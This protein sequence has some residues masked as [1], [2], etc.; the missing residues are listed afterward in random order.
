MKSVI[1]QQ[2]REK[3]RTV[4]NRH[5]KIKETLLIQELKPTLNDT[6]SSEKLY[7]FQFAFFNASFSQ[8]LSLLLLIISPARFSWTSDINQNMEKHQVLT[9]NKKFY[10][11][12]DTRHIYLLQNVVF[13]DEGFG[14]NHAF[15]ANRIYNVSILG[16]SRVK[17]EHIQI[18][19]VRANSRKIT[20]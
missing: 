8:L 15:H 14:R 6:V 10:L 4:T 1:H 16:S 19:K 17:L 18:C 3:D 20:K 13:C 12:L 7:L 5:C 9:K 11:K 2:K